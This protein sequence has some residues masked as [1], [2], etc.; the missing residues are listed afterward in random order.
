MK[1][2]VLLTGFLAVL[3]IC[4]GAAYM[5]LPWLVGLGA[6]HVLAEHGYHDAK[7]NV[8][9]VG[10][11]RAIVENIDL[12]SNSNVRAKSLTVDY[13]L[14]RIFGGTIDGLSIDTPELPIGFDFSGI[15][16]GPLAVF[17]GDGS[18]ES[19]LKIRGPIKVNNGRVQI[20]SPLGEVKAVIDGDILLTDDLG[21]QAHIEFAL[22]HPK[23]RING[24]MR[25]IL[26]ASNQLQL[27]LDI[28]DA[29][30]DAEI[31]FAEMAGAINIKGQFPAALTGG[32]SLSLKDVIM[33]GVDIGDVDLVGGIDGRSAEAEFLLGGADTGLSLQLRA[34]TNDILDPQSEMRLSGEMA[35][36]GLRGPFELPGNLDLVGAVAFDIKG[37]IEDLKLLPGRLQS[38]AVRTSNT[39]SGWVDVSQLG[40]NLVDHEIDMTVNGKASLLI[41]QRGWRLQPFAGINFDVGLEAGRAYKRVEMTL[42]AIDDVPFLVGGPNRTDPLRIGAIFDGLYNNWFPFSGD[43]GGIVWPSTTD[44]VVFEDFSVRL[45][46][47]QMRVG[48]LDFTSDSVKVRLSGTASNPSLS[49]GMDASLSG[50]VLPGYR[51]NGGR[52]SVD[53]Q[54]GY[55]GSGIKLFPQGCIAAQATS[56]E[57]N[58]ATLRPGPIAL[59]PDENGAPLIHAVMGA[60]GLKRIDVAGL[61]KTLEF[62]LKGVGEHAL[63]GTSPSLTGTG[64]FDLTRGTWWVKMLPRGGDILIEG[65]DVAIAGLDGTLSLE[66]REKLLGTKLD[67]AAGKIVDRRRPLRFTPAKVRGVAGLAAGSMNFKGHLGFE[68]GPEASVEMRH[69]FQNSRGRF[70]FKL[71]RWAILANKAQPDDLVPLLRG[72]ITDVSGAINADAEINWSGARMT[73]NGSIGFTDLDFGTSPA[74]FKGVNGTIVFD[75]LISLKSKGEQRLAIGLT[76]PGLP[77]R[78]GEI[79]FDL[80]GDNSAKVLTAKWPLA[81]GSISLRDVNIPFDSV[82]SSFVATIKSLDAQEIA[83]SIDVEDLQAEGKLEGSVPVRITDTGPIIDNARIWTVTPGVLRFRSQAAV[84]SLKQ[85][86]EMAEL[87]AKALANFQYTN[88]DISLDGPL[89]GDI[90]ASAKI[91]GANPDLYEG[92]KIELNVNLH[93]ALRDLMQSASVFKDLP[94]TIRDQV[95]GPSGKP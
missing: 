93:G 95:Q 31:Q 50:E 75:D 23:A 64:S 55:G 7:L 25:A 1:K 73:S 58:D 82:L 14:E 12:G 20:A 70:E 8:Q 87:L 60:D 83:R 67:L 92:K 68:D 39:V 26:D 85:S 81:G 11:A 27:N 65:P 54:I 24:R 53:S 3:L 62:E 6:K 59:C 29:A 51:I 18:G 33:R 36:D 66:G 10:F 47:W 72:Y 57:M 2:P 37:P 88:I 40:V 28:Q 52:I 13:A 34:K 38:G 86:G 22:Q 61:L 35:T 5:S 43:A 74:A 15:E 78:N 76:D 91:N 77:L 94:E 41:D 42:D 4:F 56:I 17:G 30:S 21:S 71:P 89:S 9:S 32:G 84:R 90:S 49:A 63:S 46:P 45:D 44:G 48:K 69:R 79:V 16:L 80:P 19:S